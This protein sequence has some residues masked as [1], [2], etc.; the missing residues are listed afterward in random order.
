[1]ALWLEVTVIT[2]DTVM[3]KRCLGGPHTGYI[4]PCVLHPSLVGSCVLFQT[5]C[6]EVHALCLMGVMV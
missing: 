4:N 3:Y 5:V 1:V 6:N 2:V